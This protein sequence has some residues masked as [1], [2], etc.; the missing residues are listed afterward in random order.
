MI[1]FFR[2]ADRLLSCIDTSATSNTPLT[3]LIALSYP[4]AFNDPF[5]C[6]ISNSGDIVANYVEKHVDF[7][8]N[9]VKGALLSDVYFYH[10]YFTLQDLDYDVIEK[11]FIA[12]DSKTTPKDYIAWGLT[13]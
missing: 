5:D 10:E 4:W 13:S 7:V 12:S 9:W 2:F 1:L 6:K 3:P 8:V 11:D